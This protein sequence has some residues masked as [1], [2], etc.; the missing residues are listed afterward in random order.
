MSTRNEAGYKLV[1]AE[2]E[3]EEFV[4][5]RRRPRRRIS[6]HVAVGLSLILTAILFYSGWRG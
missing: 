1:R 4:V 5:Q 2:E 6:C 3:G